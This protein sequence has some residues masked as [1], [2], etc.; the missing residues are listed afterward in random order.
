MTQDPTVITFCSDIFGMEGTLA[1]VFID[2]GLSFS[3]KEFLFTTQWGFVHILSSPV[4]TVNGYID[5]RTLCMHYQKHPTALSTASFPVS[6]PGTKPDKL[7]L[8]LAW[9]AGGLI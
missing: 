6:I 3:N 9:P 1:E 5:V 7:H 8:N 4:S 2:N